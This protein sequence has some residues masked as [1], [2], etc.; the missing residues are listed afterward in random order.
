MEDLSPFSNQHTS[1]R[2]PRYSMAPFRRPVNHLSMHPR[3]QRLASADPRAL[4]QCESVVSREYDIQRRYRFPYHALAHT[5]TVE[6]AHGPRTQDGVDRFLLLCL[7]V[8]SPVQKTSRF[9]D[10]CR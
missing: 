5:G 2:R 6:P 10:I 8:S 3:A 7:L 1:C 9:L 4:P